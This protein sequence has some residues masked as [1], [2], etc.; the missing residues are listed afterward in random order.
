MEMQYLSQ[1]WRN[2]SFFRLLKK[3]A[4]P[5][6]NSK[7]V[8]YDSGTN[9]IMIHRS[10]FSQN[11]SITVAYTPFPCLFLAKL[12]PWFLFYFYPSFCSS[13]DRSI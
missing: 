4:T 12:N 8:R 9:S 2:S 7:R 10:K 13:W 6:K 1:S 11:G 5:K 3:S